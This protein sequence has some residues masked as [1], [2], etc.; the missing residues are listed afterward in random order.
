MQ[1][2]MS[3]PIA[4]ACAAALAAVAFVARGRQWQRGLRK[5]RASK[6]EFDTLLHEIQ[7]MPRNRN[8]QHGPA[9]RQLLLRLVKLSTLGLSEGALRAL[10]EHQKIQRALPGV[11]DHHGLCSGQPRKSSVLA[12]AHRKVVVQWLIEC[13]ERLLK[14]L[15]P[16]K[17]YRK[18]APKIRTRL[19]KLTSQQTNAE[20]D[21]EAQRTA[22]GGQLSRSLNTQ[23]AADEPPP[24]LQNDVAHFYAAS[25]FPPPSAG[26]QH[27]DLAVYLATTFAGFEH[28]CVEEISRVLGV[29]MTQIFAV[30]PQG[31]LVD[32]RSVMVSRGFGI[33]IT[34]TTTTTTTTATTTSTSTTTAFSL[35]C[36]FV[37]KSLLTSG[38]IR[39]FVF[40][41]G[42]KCP[43]NMH[44]ASPVV[45]ELKQELPSVG[46]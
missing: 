8:P 11:G 25:V 46:K 41:T 16:R 45:L 27:Q 42:R 24:P 26:A 37:S 15:T 18:I 4:C 9:R 34:T 35:P 17:K 13:A 44:A 6:R 29:K 2:D 7:V 28:V 14:V 20:N 33:P 21:N 32:G 43:R 22:P 31:E 12:A 10:W 38:A 19:E 40:N 36:A 3:T 39:G 23:D 5:F 30:T 1:R